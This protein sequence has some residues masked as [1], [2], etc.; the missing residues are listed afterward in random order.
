MRGT[1]E[2]KSA[3]YMRSM[4]C[5]EEWVRM[6]IV[7]PGT[8]FAVSEYSD[9]WYKLETPSGERWWV[10]APNRLTNINT[11]ELDTSEHMSD[12]K[13]KVTMRKN[14]LSLTKFKRALAS[15]KK[16]YSEDKKE[17]LIA[18]F[19]AIKA[20]A[21]ELT[22]FVDHVIVQISSN[23]DKASLCL[24]KWGERSSIHN[25]CVGVDAVSCQAM[26]G[27]FDECAS[28]CR[29]N[30]EAQACTMQ[31]VPVCQL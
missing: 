24:A 18:H 22:S 17:S 21:P 30:P 11:Y 31:C 14:V 27:S 19:T 2:P 10:Y 13:P 8:S 23:A 6:S 28:A 16:N 15:I 29:H 5:M 26:Q 20:E 4:P 7:R 3:V 1:V 9:G 12:D 25:E